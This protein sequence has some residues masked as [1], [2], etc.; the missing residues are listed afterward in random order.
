MK[1][2]LKCGSNI[3]NDYLNIDKLDSSL[4]Q[5]LYK[6]GDY[7]NLDW[8]CQNESVEEIKSNDTICFSDLKDS[9]NVI[10]SWRSKLQNNGKLTFQFNDIYSLCK[11]FYNDQ[12]N[13]EELNRGIFLQSNTISVFDRSYIVNLLMNNG[14][15][16]EKLFYQ[17]LS[18][19]IEAARI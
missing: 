15:K 17:S 12:I 9:I 14:F 5:E 1:L 10:N 11:A 13:L 19:Y 6:K 16:I 4:P 2:N 7:L 18:V 3:L 8:L